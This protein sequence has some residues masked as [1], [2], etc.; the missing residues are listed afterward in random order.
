MEAMRREME[1]HFQQQLNAQLEQLRA[2]VT[3]SQQ[4]VETARMDAN[5]LQ[6]ELNQARVAIHNAASTTAAPIQSNQTVRTKPP[7]RFNGRRD[8][9]AVSTFIYAVRNYVVLARTPVADQISLFA[10]LLEGNA[11]IWWMQ[12]EAHAPEEQ[13]STLDQALEALQATFSPH[14]AVNRARAELALLR[15]T[16]SLRDYINQFMNLSLIAHN[17]TDL[18]KCELFRRGL[19]DQ[20]RTHVYLQEAKTLSKA[21]AIADLYDRSQTM[22]RLDRTVTIRPS[23]PGGPPSGSAIPMEIDSVSAQRV[24]IEKRLSRSQNSQSAERR[25]RC[26]EQNLCFGCESPD[27]KYPD[28]PQRKRRTHFR[29]RQD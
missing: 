4:Q 8:A 24:P 13:R 20:Y 15:H 18:E 26:R 2:E 7:T 11:L 29:E 28:C 12:H 16:G 19:K 1:A 25:R 22:S 10:S 14:D 5:R 27:H 23:G 9:V 17:L 21:I 3:A 6:S